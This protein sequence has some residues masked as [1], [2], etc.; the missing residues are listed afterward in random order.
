M[1]L[2]TVAGC[3]SDRTLVAFVPVLGGG[4]VAGCFP[5]ILGCP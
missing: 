2:A 3:H 5:E 1:T 4:A